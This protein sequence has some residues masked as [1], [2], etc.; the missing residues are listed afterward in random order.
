MCEMH[1]MCETGKTAKMGKIT[2]VILAAG[3]G[4][5]M[6]KN[7]LALPWQGEKTVLEATIAKITASTIK[8]GVV[9]LGYES[10]FW[11]QRL[12]LPEGW[13]TVVNPDFALG[14]STSLKAGLQAV[15]KDTDAILFCL[16][17]QPLIQTE[18]V[19]A[20]LQ[21]WQEKKPAI[22]LPTYKGRRGNPVLFGAQTFSGMKELTGD[23]GARSLFAVYEPLE[24]PVQDR[25]IVV[26]LDTIEVYEAERRDLGCSF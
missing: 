25:G 14:Q 17:D 5:R 20:L 16:G 26:D 18:T 10:A 8:Q 22:L 21:A 7:K 23:A 9:V 6:G 24:F 13:Q 15:A 19:Q 2:A 11:L 1:E 4:S 12:A 3:F